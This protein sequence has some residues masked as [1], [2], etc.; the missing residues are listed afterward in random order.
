M[1]KSE[2]E[3]R[4][5]QKKPKPT[6]VTINAGTMYESSSHPNAVELCHHIWFICNRSGAK[7]GFFVPE[8]TLYADS[9]SVSVPP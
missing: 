4:P 3:K 2:R 5:L 7:G 9:Y 8:L 6:T 1:I